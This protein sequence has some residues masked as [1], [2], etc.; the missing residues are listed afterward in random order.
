MYLDDTPLGVK[1]ENENADFIMTYE[2]FPDQAQDDVDRPKMVMIHGFGGSGL[3][4]YRILKHLH[5]DFKIYL[6]DLPGMGRSSRHDF[7]HDT[8]E[9]CD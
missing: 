3:I 8:F 9:N 1:S 5:E 6:I 4:F 7:P 2:L